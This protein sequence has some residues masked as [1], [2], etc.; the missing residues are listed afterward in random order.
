MNHPSLHLFILSSSSSSSKPH[1]LFFL[2]VS[3]F[4]QWRTLLTTSLRKSPSKAS[5]TTVNCSITFFTM[6][7]NAKLVA[8]SWRNLKELE[9]SLRSLSLSILFFFFLLFRF[10]FSLSRRR[11]RCLVLCTADVFFSFGVWEMEE[12]IHDMLDLRVRC[13]F[14]CS[15]RRN[16]NHAL[17]YGKIYA[18]DF[19][20]VDFS[21]SCQW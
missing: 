20:D 13:F 4:H 15:E 18:R 2:S 3:S 6:S 19:V 11:R 21:L 9:S 1:S 17:D 16:L 12:S 7:C 8:N 10:F 14:L 5:M